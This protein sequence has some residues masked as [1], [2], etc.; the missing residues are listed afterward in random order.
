MEEKK[1]QGV[2]EA[3]SLDFS[4]HKKKRQEF[5]ID[6]EPVRSNKLLKVLLSILAALII[7]TLIGAIAFVLLR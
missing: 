4:Q 3:G 5:S 1:G 6:S 7:L 2:T